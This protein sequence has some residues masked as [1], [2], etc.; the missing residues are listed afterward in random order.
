M[1][2][3]AI[4]LLPVF[5]LASCGHGTTKSTSSTPVHKTL[6][7]RCNETSGFMQDSHGNWKPRDDRRSEFDSVGTSPYFK[8]NYQ[9]KECRTPTLES[10]P[11]WGSKDYT[12]K[13]FAGK[14]NGSQWQKSARADGQRSQEDGSVSSANSKAVK[15]NGFKTQAARE[16]KQ[17]EINRPADVQT[18]SVD[19]SYVPPEIIDW[20]QQ[21]VMSMD[22]TKSIL[23]H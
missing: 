21:R 19:R 18:Q 9:T 13:A 2:R 17:G 7:E 5:W 8:G 20:Q 15:T 6:E 23:G 14:S 11:W 10:K 1:K 16:T 22:E 3:I 4:T 12:T